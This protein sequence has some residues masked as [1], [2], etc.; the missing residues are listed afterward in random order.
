MTWT[1]VCEVAALSNKREVCRLLPQDG[2]I[3]TD[4]EHPWAINQIEIDP[5][6]WAISLLMRFSKWVALHFPKR[7]LQ[8]HMS[9]MPL[10]LFWESPD[11]R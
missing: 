8:R 5:N 7:C 3:F 6:F 10:P 11:I 9:S 1:G 4:F 2:K